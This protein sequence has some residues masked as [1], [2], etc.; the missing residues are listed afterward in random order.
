MPIDPGSA[1]LALTWP[2]H[3]WVCFGSS[4]NPISNPD[5]GWIYG[6]QKDLKSLSDS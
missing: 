4:S 1:C 3:T 6:A 2:S 5:E